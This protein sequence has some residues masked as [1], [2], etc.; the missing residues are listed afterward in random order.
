M[1]EQMDFK[2]IAEGFEHTDPIEPV[3]VKE[4]EYIPASQYE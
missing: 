2:E 4:P 1:E 3:E